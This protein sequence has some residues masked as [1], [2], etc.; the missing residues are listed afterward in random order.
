MRAALTALASFALVL[1]SSTAGALAP[2]SPADGRTLMSAADV[3]ALAAKLKAE[4]KDQPILAQTMLRAAGY[5]VN[6]EYRT[7]VGPAAVHDND[8]EFFYVIDGAGTVVLGGK[9]ANEKRTNAANLTGTGI[10]G[11]TA[12]KVAKGD[13]IM[14]PEG[15]PHWFSAIDGTLVLMALHLPRQAPH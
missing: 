6:M 3:T 4:R 5:N 15:T 9:L 8:A 14:V 2:A 11:G 7:A 12:R 13:F 10:E 1:V